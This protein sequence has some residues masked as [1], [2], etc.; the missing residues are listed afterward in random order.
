MGCSEQVAKC[1]RGAAHLCS[2]CFAGG[3]LHVMC[4]AKCRRWAAAYPWPL[5]MVV[6]EWEGCAGVQRGAR[7]AA[8]IGY[9]SATCS[10]S[11]LAP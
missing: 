5:P 10:L 9:L 8:R 4:V 6:V 3:M 1:L 7:P 2:S 11:L